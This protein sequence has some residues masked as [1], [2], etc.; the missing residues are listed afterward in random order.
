MEIL[1]TAGDHDCDLEADVLVVFP[2]TDFPS[3]M[4]PSL[5]VGLLWG[6]QLSGFAIAN[7]MGC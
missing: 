4:Q 1:A 6:P 3:C 5:L 2:E 7:L